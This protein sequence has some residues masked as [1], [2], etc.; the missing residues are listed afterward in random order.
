MTT[1]ENPS[2]KRTY[3][4]SNEI[5]VEERPNDRIST[6]N[7]DGI[8]FDDRNSLINFNRVYHLYYQCLES[9]DDQMR[10]QCVRF[11][12]DYHQHK[13]L[14]YIDVQGYTKFIVDLFFD[15]SLDVISNMSS[16]GHSDHKTLVENIYNKIR[17]DKRKLNDDSDQLAKRIDVYKEC[18]FSKA[19]QK[20]HL[21]FDYNSFH[22]SITHQEEE[23]EDN[24]NINE[25]ED[26]VSNTIVNQEKDIKLEINDLTK[27]KEGYHHAISSTMIEEVFTFTLSDILVE[28]IISFSLKGDSLHIFVENTRIRILDYSDIKC[29]FNIAL[30]SK[31]FFRVASKKINNS[32]HNLYGHINVDN[33][34]SL[35]KSP[36]LYFDYESIKFIR[37][38]ESTVRIT[39]LFSRVEIFKLSSDEYD[40]RINDGVF[41]RYLYDDFFGRDTEHFYRNSISRNDYLTYLPP[42]PNLKHFTIDTYFG[43]KR[44]YSSFL[45]SIFENTPNVD[46]HGIESFYISIYKDWNGSPDY[47]NLDF[48]QPLLSLHSKTLKSVT[49]D[50]RRLCG[51]Y[52]YEFLP[53]LKEM[54]PTIKQYN[55]SFILYGSFYN[56][57]SACK[58]DEDLEVYRY[59]LNQKVILNKFD[60]R[61]DDIDKNDLEYIQETKNK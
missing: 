38:D 25:N 32:Y 56:L 15:P 36:P 31:Q 8:D 48:L 61:N 22:Y 10:S 2:R 14:H 19:I 30:V 40:S 17:Y 33:E 60:S 24:D 16:F 20:K 3:Q 42:M 27:E 47:S 26:G 55:Y 28:I 9:R 53:I 49:L 35:I 7:I 1:T 45:I 13:F 37:Y 6:I 41:R 46:G 52:A 54:L 39:Q 59:L 51:K 29:I 50:Y 21:Y 44:N 12:V 4:E 43:Y 5:V 18:F 58:D 57:K 34:Y 23:E 11:F